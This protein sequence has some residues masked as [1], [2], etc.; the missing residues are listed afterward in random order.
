MTNKLKPELLTKKEAAE[1]LGVSES[2]FAKLEQS[3]AI[4]APRMLAG[5]EKYLRVDIKKAARGLPK[6]TAKKPRGPEKCDQ[7][8]GTGG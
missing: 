7:I 1:M 6:A 5:R 2:D 3:K 8:F 4:P